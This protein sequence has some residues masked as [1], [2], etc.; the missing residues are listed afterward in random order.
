MPGRSQPDNALFV[1]FA[2]HSQQ[3]QLLAKAWLAVRPTGVSDYLFVNPGAR[4]EEQIS[5]QTV[6]EVLRRLKELVVTA[7]QA[8]NG[9]V[10]LVRPTS[11]VVMGGLAI[12]CVGYG[13]WWRFVWPVL[14]LLAILSMLML[15]VG[16][17]I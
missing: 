14:I 12:A 4:Y 8:A 13:A 6:S 1:S 2:L 5:T 3:N 9:L 11:A 15:A 10:N 17:L 7:Y 16:V